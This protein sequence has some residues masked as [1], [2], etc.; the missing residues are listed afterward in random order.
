MTDKSSIN[1]YG[2][3]I[4]QSLQ[5]KI[6][7]L[8]F[9]VQEL[10]DAEICELFTFDGGIQ[11]NYCVLYGGKKVCIHITLTQGVEFAES[12]RRQDEFVAMRGKQ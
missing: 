2:V 4:K 3:E 9:F 11:E 8:I 12:K 6:R 7:E 10:S 1:P 5:A